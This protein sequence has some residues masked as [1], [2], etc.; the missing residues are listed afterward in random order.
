MIKM[1][2]PGNQD[3]TFMVRTKGGTTY[4]RA[5]PTD[6]T[7]VTDITEPITEL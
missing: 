2:I 4:D 5:Y 1:Y 3:V 6:K 7:A